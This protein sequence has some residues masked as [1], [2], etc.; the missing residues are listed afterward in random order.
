MSDP[1]AGAVTCPVTTLAPGD[2]TICTAD[3]ADVDHRRLMSTPGSCHNRATGH[4]TPP[5][6]CRRPNPP[7]TDTP[8]DQAPGPG[9][10]QVGS[11][12]TDVNGN[13]LT[14][15]GDEINWEFELTNTGTSRSPIWRS[16]TRPAGPVTCPVTTL[17]AGAS[18]VCTIDNAYVITPADVDAGVVHNRAVATGEGPG[19]DPDDPSDDVPSNPDTTDTPTDQRPKLALDKRVSSVTDVNGNGLTDAGDEINYE[20]ELTNTGNV[21]LT[22]VNVS[23]PLVG[24]VICPTG[25][26]AAGDSTVCHGHAP[27]VITQADVDA[28]SVHNRAIGQADGQC[29]DGDKPGGKPG[30]GAQH[31]RVSCVVPSNPDTTDTPTDQVPD[32]TLDKR[33]A[34][35]TD[36]NH[37]G[38]TDAG[39]KID[40]EFELTNTGSVT[41]TDLEVSDPMIG[42]VTCPVGPLA[43]G[44]SVVCVGD[45]PHVVTAADVNAGHVRNTATATGT[46]PGGP[47]VGSP[48][49]TVTTPVDPNLPNQPGGEYP[50][51]PNT[52][53]PTFWALLGGLLLLVGGGVLTR[54]SRRR[55]A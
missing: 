49:D 12:V 48:P 37:N 51:L 14:D 32:L 17:A 35:V 44:D 50:H 30:R 38:I 53:G 13:G 39:D 11:S 28:G 7:S 27:Y 2:S 10:D 5:T 8:I 40:Y 55:R 19:G 45:H 31:A 33:V 43:A 42:S 29:S 41:L 24:A 16:P 15:A 20:F 23:D 18:T 34:S 4:G 47:N 1:T 9:A 3:D 22:N 36:V 21:T 25:P 6:R 54:T 46:P 26:L 52:G